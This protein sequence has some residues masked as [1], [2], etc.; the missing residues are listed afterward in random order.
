MLLDPDSLRT[1][2]ACL[3]SI[4]KGSIRLVTQALCDF[5]EVAADIF[6]RERDLAQDIAEDI[7]REA[8][9]RIGVS[10]IDTRLFG[11]MDYKRAR[12]VL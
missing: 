7:T 8:L 1:N 10:K 2:P 6:R 9:D 3:E 5:R 12:Y 11:K 4:E